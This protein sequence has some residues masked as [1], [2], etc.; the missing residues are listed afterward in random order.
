MDQLSLCL[1]NHT[2]QPTADMRA[3]Q[4]MPA[5]ISAAMTGKHKAACYFLWPTT[6]QDASTDEAGMVHKVPSP[7]PPSPSRTPS[8]RSL[9]S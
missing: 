2:T 1:N 4:L 3:V 8:Y 7:P 9:S 5:A 6:F